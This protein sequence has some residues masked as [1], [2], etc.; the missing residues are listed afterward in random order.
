MPGIQFAEPEKKP[1]AERPGRERDVLEKGSTQRAPSP[2][3][4]IVYPSGWRLVLMTI[5]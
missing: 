4:D 1:D 3:T 5:G 2:G